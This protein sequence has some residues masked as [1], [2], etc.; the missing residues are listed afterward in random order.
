MYKGKGGIKKREIPKDITPMA[1]NMPSFMIRRLLSKEPL[2]SAG[3]SAPCT[4]TVTIMMA[5]L[6]SASVLAFASC[7]ALAPT[8][9]ASPSTHPQPLTFAISRYSVNGKLIP[10][11]K[12]TITALRSAMTPSTGISFKLGHIA[13]KTWGIVSPTMTAKATI[14]PNAKAHCAT[15]I[16][17]SPALPKQCST[18]PWKLFAPLSLLFTTMRR[19]VQSTASVRSTRRRMPERR[20]AC[21]R[22]Y[23][24]P[25]IPAPM[26]EFA[27]FMKAERRPDLGRWRSESAQSWTSLSPHGPLASA[28]AGASMSVRS[29]RRVCDPPSTSRSSPPYPSS[30]SRSEPESESEDRL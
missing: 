18:V 21:R 26:I 17:I 5:M 16:A 1:W 9:C 8:I 30:R 2:N 20:P 14:P 6:M 28:T 29:G 25:I 12:T 4:T 22:A 3:A 15:D 13:S 10:M 23:G 11:T 27:M 19:T 24:C 7:S